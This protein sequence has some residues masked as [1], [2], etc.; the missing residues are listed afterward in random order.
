M[1]LQS[2]VERIGACTMKQVWR[3]A[4]VLRPTE[5][6]EIGMDDVIRVLVAGLLLFGAAMGL[7]VLLGAY[8]VNG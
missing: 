5:S 6:K 4:F 2:Y 8:F 1:L 7:L 3:G